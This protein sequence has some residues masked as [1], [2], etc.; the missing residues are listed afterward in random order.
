[1]TMLLA[2]AIPLLFGAFCLV[3]PT[4][5]L[6]MAALVAGACAHLAVV[7]L[8]WPSAETPAGQDLVGLDPL[9]H[10][11][12]TII[13]VLFAATTVYFVGYHRKQLVSQR[14]FQACI[15]GLLSSLSLLCIS[16][17]LGLLW[18]AMES[19]SLAAT[20]L[21]YFRLG[22]RALEAT[23]KFLLMNSVGVALALLGIF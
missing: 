14:I 5:P 20:P 16:Q 11:F 8:S 4:S 6:R 23:W 22:P 19:A 18:V 7:A 13:S 2:V 21:I 1:M 12:L 15:L 9:G 3:L 17:H 10:L